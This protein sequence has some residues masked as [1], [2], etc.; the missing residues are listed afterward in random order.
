M[1]PF[2]TITADDIELIGSFFEGE[3]RERTMRALNRYCEAG[4]NELAMVVV[5]NMLVLRQETTHLYV[6]AMPTEKPGTSGNMRLVLMQLM[7]SA[8]LVGNEWLIVGV[9][10]HEKAMLRSALPHHFKFSGE[11]KYSYLDI[12]RLSKRVTDEP[13]LAAVPTKSYGDSIFANNETMVPT[14]GEFGY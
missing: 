10:E 1:L 11:E 9:R 5:E 8:E 2:K 3:K 12:V 7:E 13:S 14:V 6:Y 4:H